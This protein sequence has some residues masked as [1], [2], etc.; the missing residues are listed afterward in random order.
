ME[1]SLWFGL[2]LIL[3]PGFSSACGK[4]KPIGLI[5]L[6]P[7]VLSEKSEPP[8]KASR[9]DLGL[10][11]VVNVGIK[12]PYHCLMCASLHFDFPVQDGFLPFG[13]QVC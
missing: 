12:V 5:T 11:M 6:I 4:V 3:V 13:L 2:I 8:P 9:L 10:K 1:V 7:S